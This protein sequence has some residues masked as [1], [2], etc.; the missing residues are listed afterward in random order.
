[1]TCTI[2]Q[3]RSKLFL[4]GS[5]AEFFDGAIAINIDDL[6]W[7]WTVK[8]GGFSFFLQFSASAHILWI[9]LRRKLQRQKR[10]C[11]LTILTLPLNYYKMATF[12]PIFFW[13]KIVPF[14]PAVSKSGGGFVGLLLLP[15]VAPPS[16]H[17]IKLYSRQNFQVL[18]PNVNFVCREPRHRANYSCKKF[19]PWPNV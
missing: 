14:I 6:E 5:Y 9:E 16:I 11:V 12:Q 17:G 13:T 1:M 2:M 18:K 8:I 7:T 15:I 19:P 3:S 4:L 10:L